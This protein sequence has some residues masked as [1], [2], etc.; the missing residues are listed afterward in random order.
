MSGEEE[1]LMGF[2]GGLGLELMREMREDM[3]MMVM[4]EVGD[5]KFLERAAIDE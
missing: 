3:M 5:G 1:L 2:D 4:R